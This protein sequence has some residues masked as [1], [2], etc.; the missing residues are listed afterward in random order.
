MSNPS[1][2]FSEF[3]DTTES[4]QLWQIW[5]SNAGFNLPTYTQVNLSN[6][7]NSATP[8]QPGLITLLNN[9]TTV[10]TIVLTFDG[11]NNISTITRTS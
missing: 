9:G 2:T 8:P 10:A 6:Y 1:L 11:S 3:V 5:N 7:N 4:E